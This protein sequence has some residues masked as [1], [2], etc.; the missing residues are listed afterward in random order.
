MVQCSIVVEGA[1]VIIDDINSLLFNAHVVGLG[2]RNNSVL[3]I[4]RM[5]AFRFYLHASK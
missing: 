4:D 3:F 2:I 5:S 1:P